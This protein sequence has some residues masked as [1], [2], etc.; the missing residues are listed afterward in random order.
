MSADVSAGGG[1]ASS[2]EDAFVLAVDLG[3][4]GPKVAVISPPGRIVP[5]ARPSRWRLH[6]L[7]GGGA[8]QDPADWWRH[9]APP[10]AR[11]LARVRASPSSGDRGG[12]HGAVVGD[13]RRR[14][15]GTPLRPAVIWMDSRGNTAI[16]RQMC[17]RSASSVTTCARSSRWIRLTGG[18]PSQ[19]GKDPTAH[20]L[21]IREAEP[22]IY[23]RRSSSSSPWTG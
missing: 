22:D 14:R 20:I 5:P 1:S 3:T 6:L 17:G 2:S 23:E 10:P 7:P 15:E 8:E 12:L 4:G 16:R 18:A 13:R 9:R 21:W 19:S 11:A